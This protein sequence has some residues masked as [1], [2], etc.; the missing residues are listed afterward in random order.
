MYIV[1]R[2]NKSKKR[3]SNPKTKV[4]K[5]LSNST[6]KAKK[7]NYEKKKWQT[8]KR[9][10]PKQREKVKNGTEIVEKEMGRKKRKR[11][12]ILTVEHKGGTYRENEDKEK[13][14]KGAPLL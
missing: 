7:E 3:M 4:R 9:N 13:R 8:G 10:W 14:E 6:K 12:V 11:K 1:K 2:E 5:R